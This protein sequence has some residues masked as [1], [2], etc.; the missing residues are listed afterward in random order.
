MVVEST[1]MVLWQEVFQSL[2]KTAVSHA[3]PRFFGLP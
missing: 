2:Q 1:V 3:V